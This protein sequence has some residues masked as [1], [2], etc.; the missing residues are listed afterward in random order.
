MKIHVQTLLTVFK[1]GLFLLAIILSILNIDDRYNTNKTTTTTWSVD[2]SEIFFPLNFSILIT[3][4][5][6]EDNLKKAGYEGI[7]SYFSGII[8][9]ENQTYNRG[10]AGKMPNVT[11]AG[12]GTSS[13]CKRF[14]A[15]SH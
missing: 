15:S 4:G 2:H 3:P 9:S 13:R 6:V 12:I 5:F 14:R 11:V 1:L 8:A 10:W 7:V